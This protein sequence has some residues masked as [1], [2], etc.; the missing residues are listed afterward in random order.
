MLFFYL[1]NNFHFSLTHLLPSQQP[2][3]LCSAFSSPYLIFNG[4]GLSMHAEIFF[5]IYLIKNSVKYFYKKKLC[6]THR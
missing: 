1:F 2:T 6:V 5:E 3:L 4:T